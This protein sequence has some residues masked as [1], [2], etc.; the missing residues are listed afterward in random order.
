MHGA[1]AGASAEA[2]CA[3]IEQLLARGKARRAVD[4][5]KDLHKSRGSPESEALLAR[6]YRA[7]IE[8]MLHQGL[9][10]DAQ[11]LLA[12]VRERYPGSFSACADV[13]ERLALRSG[14]GLDG[15]ARLAAADLTDEE[16][17]GLESLV[18][19]SVGDPRQVADFAALPATHPLRL[20]AAAIVC[21]L[22]AVTSRAVTEAELALPEVSR[23]SPFASWKLLVR[24]VAR[25][26]QRQDEECRKCLAALAADAVP[27]RLAPLLQGL[28]D[29]KRPP[30]PAGQMAL[31]AAI[32]G[33]TPRLR[34]TLADLD[35][36]FRSGR[37]KAVIAA[38]ATAV[39]ECRRQRPELL[40][41]LRQHISASAL[42]IGVAAEP[43]RRALGASSVKDAYFWR[44]FARVCEKQAETH[45]LAALF[46]ACAAWEEFRRHAVHQGWFAPGGPEEAA[47]YLHLLDILATLPWE[48]FVEERGDFVHSFRRLGGMA[49]YYRAEE[50]QPAAVM[51]CAPPAPPETYFLYPELLFGRACQA[52]P[53]PDLFRRWLDWTQDHEMGPRAADEV[54]TAWHAACPTDPRPLLVLAENAEARDAFGKALK[55]LKAA[56][57]LDGMNVEVRRARPRLVL[58][59][60]LRHLRKQQHLV[61]KDVAELAALPQMG[62]GDR[63]VLTEAVRWVAGAMAA[64]P[65]D[66]DWAMQGL[67]AAAG[68]RQTA[69]YAAHLI[70]FESEAHALVSAL[71]ARL[72]RPDLESVAFLR[73]AARVR[74]LWG[75]MHLS[76]SMPNAW[77]AALPAAVQHA[78]AN[79]TEVQL[80]CLAEFMVS[81][82]SAGTGAAS[83]VAMAPLAYHLAGL[84]LRRPDADHGQFLLLRGQ[85]LLIEDARAPE[86]GLRCLRAARVLAARRRDMALVEAAWDTERRYRY[87]VSAPFDSW[88][89]AS[90]HLNLLSTEEIQRVLTAER[91]GLAFPLLQPQRQAAASRP[92]ARL[93][94]SA[95]ADRRQGFLPGL[96]FPDAAEDDLAEVD[97]DDEAAAARA[98][99]LPLSFL[100]ADELD[101][102]LDDELDDELDRL[103]ADLPPG[104]AALLDKLIAKYGE[105]AFQM[106][107]TPD[108]LARKEPR[109]F[110]ELL[111]IVEESDHGPG[112]FL[113]PE[114][115]RGRRK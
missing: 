28:L 70:A 84:A 36:A 64:R 30:A 72:Q 86:R 62:E 68:D 113:P 92:R 25:F 97:A 37:T 18:R 20:E 35:R 108:A 10:K 106:L 63:P 65:A 91:D 22:S 50:G 8:E 112:G 29:G 14:K 43:V 105:K 52:T 78:D 21:A 39:Q 40:D 6:A 26:Y 17:E 100:D 82:R 49:M 110:Q 57:A 54:A 23:H 104:M 83:S 45:D 98:D 69:I 115:R 76:F 53:T 33:D 31:A 56:E 73:A 67:V 103:A 46:S 94:R 38:I 42:A 3:E 87:L 114:P 16:R 19:R 109:L 60:A 66:A 4:L 75:E 102:D 93:P 96:G 61:G 107:M 55:F 9:T 80:R 32:A 11:A 89:D 90:D 5:A 88:D 74:T 7:R 1:S 41:R 48:D 13:E 47:V 101:D 85:S 111:R 71:L 81:C 15:L 24:A 59:T 27:A 44:L 99:D 12:L 77:V 95:A 79:L 51:A 58:A 34:Q 2:R